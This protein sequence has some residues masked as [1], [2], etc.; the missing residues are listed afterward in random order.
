MRR[1]LYFYTL[2]DAVLAS[3]AA[4]FAGEG[5]CWLP[6]PAEAVA[7]GFLVD[8]SAEGA[9]PRPVARHRVVATVGAPLE[10]SDRLLRS[11]TWRSATAPG[12]FPVFDGDLEL[13]GLQ[14]GGCHL[15][16]M[17]TYRPPLS[18]AGAAGDAVLGHHV[19]EACIRRFV[20][21]TADRLAAVTLPA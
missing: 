14:G 17:G 16:L 21:D 8:V 6:A 7:G 9:L 1:H 2:V 11:I 3:A 13:R 18:V 5:A 4:T 12:I 19:A 10:E 15:S 20:L